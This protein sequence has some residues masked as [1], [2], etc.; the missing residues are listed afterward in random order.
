VEV[1]KEP[2]HRFFNR[3]GE[4]PKVMMQFHSLE[5]AP[6]NWE[7]DEAANTKATWHLAFENNMII[8]EKDNEFIKEWNDLFHEFTTSPF[9]K[10]ETKMIECG[11]NEYRWTHP[12]DRYLTSMDAL[13][14]V[15]GCRQKQVLSDPGKYANIKNA[16][17][18][19]KIWSFNGFNGLQ[20]FRYY[21]DYTFA[22]GGQ[23]N[24]AP[25][26]MYRVSIAFNDATIGTV[27]KGIK[28]YSWNIH[29]LNVFM[30]QNRHDNFSSEAHPH[31]YFF[32]YLYNGT[33]HEFYSTD[34]LHVRARQS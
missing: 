29:F 7:V 3:F 2:T 17:D 10:T 34:K 22:Y 6:F 33:E 23:I 30:E 19:Y 26:A 11:T 14:A 9:A 32:K 12:H 25:E 8:A 28:M 21:N 13:K 27:Y 20:K 4:H 16:A 24:N 31:S 15:V 18:Y 1:A 5:G